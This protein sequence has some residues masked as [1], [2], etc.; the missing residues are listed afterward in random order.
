VTTLTIKPAVHGWALYDPDGELIAGA[1]KAAQLEARAN[2]DGFSAVI[3]GGKYR[4][5]QA[6][7]FL[8]LARGWTAATVVRYG[9]PQEQHDPADLAVLVRV[10]GRPF[11]V[12]ESRLREQPGRGEG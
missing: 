5:G 12:P 2:Y 7:E 3:A 4:P 6:V 1:R 8:S 10:S 9:E 11:L